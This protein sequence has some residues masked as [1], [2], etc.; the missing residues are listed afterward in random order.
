MARHHRL[1]EEV[2]LGGV[3]WAI[4][5]AVFLAAVGGTVSLTLELYPFLKEPGV[6]WGVAAMLIPLFAMIFAVAFIMVKLRQLEQ[7]NHH[8]D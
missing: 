2:K 3:F 7:S 5:T 8:E 4:S 6:R 1:I